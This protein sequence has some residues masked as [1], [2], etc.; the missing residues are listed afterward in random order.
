MILNLN[1]QTIL[2]VTIHHTCSTLSPER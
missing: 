1:K 2:I